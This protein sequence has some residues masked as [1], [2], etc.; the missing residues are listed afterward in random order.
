MLNFGDNSI[1]ATASRTPTSLVRAVVLGV[2][3][4][5]DLVGDRTVDVEAGTVQDELGGTVAVFRRGLGEARLQ[6]RADRDGRQGCLSVGRNRHDGKK[7]KSDRRDRGEREWP[8]T[9]GRSHTTTFIEHEESFGSS[10]RGALEGDHDDSF[11]TR[12]A[13]CAWLPR[14]M[15]QSAVHCDHVGRAA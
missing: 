14:T 1:R 12:T 2:E 5:L 11:T 4:E 6:A 3:H 9:S 7:C 10:A 13:T 8:S 15:L